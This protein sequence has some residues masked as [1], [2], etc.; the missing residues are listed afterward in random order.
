MSTLSACGYVTAM[1]AADVTPAYDASNGVEQAIVSN[2]GGPFDP[3]CSVA[4][5]GERY[6]DVIVDA[7]AVVLSVECSRI[8]G[9]FGE[10][11]E[12]L[13]SANLAFEAEAGRRYQIEFSEDFGF[14]HVA[15]TA[16]GEASPV[17]HRSLVDSRLPARPGAPHVTLV[18]RSG[19]GLIPCRF[20]RPWS[21]DTASSLRRTAAS[22]EDEPYSHQ[23][24]AEC[25]TYAYVTG[26]VKAR[27]EAPIEFVPESG[28]LYTVH[29]DEENPDFVFVTD[30]S[31]DVRTVA[32]V[33]ATRTL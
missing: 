24:V 18:S 29:M 32:Y 8:S 25:S 22:F 1:T 31:S 26:D 10:R 7:G 13:G 14:P 2:V 9:I 21:R 6:R 12:R 30:V 5:D 28:R 27:Y 4:H 3:A 19:P 23:I 15:V 11:V 33:R 20:G 17:I 16:A